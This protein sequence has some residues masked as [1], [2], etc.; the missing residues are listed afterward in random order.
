MRGMHYLCIIMKKY[1][2]PLWT[3][4]LLFV[5]VTGMAIYF[6]PR[7]TEMSVTE[8]V[9]TVAVSYLLVVIVGGVMLFREKL[10]NK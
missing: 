7:N 3:C 10:R 8:K 5:Y 1:K 9:V 4:V 6:V 2:K